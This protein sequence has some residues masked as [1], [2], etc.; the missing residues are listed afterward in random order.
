MRLSITTVLGSGVSPQASRHVRR[1]RSSSRRH[2]PS[3]VQRANS[4]KSVPKGMPESWPMA[5]HCMP[6]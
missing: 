2:S 6:Q 5:R 1:S 3:R 4:A